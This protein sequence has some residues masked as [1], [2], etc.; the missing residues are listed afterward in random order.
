M[1]T[2]LEIAGLANVSAE[3]VLR[4]VNGEPVSSEVA[5]KVARAIET[6]GPPAA[7]RLNAEVVPADSRSGSEANELV[8]RVD[9]MA[10]DLEARLPR[11][12]GSI[13]YEALRVQVQP[14][15]RHIA[16]L[17]ALYQLI[18][19]RLEDMR[20]QIERERHERLEDVALLSELVS[21]GWR[22]A[23]RR[24]ARMERMLTRLEEAIGGER[25]PLQV[26]FPATAEEK[27]IELNESATG[28]L[29][30]EP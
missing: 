25:N 16:E 29:S 28:R 5:S 2:I 6:V 20:L 11:N 7:G 21:A 19:G 22:S 24:L 26:H 1:A 30:D 12:V 17:D 9:Q 14:V 3:N 23:D 13:L 4:V 15:S 18:N 8:S 10:A 27:T